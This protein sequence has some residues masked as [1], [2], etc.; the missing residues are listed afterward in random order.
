MAALICILTAFSV[1][2]QI[3]LILRLFILKPFYL[4]AKVQIQIRAPLKLL[5]K[6]FISVISKND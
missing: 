1:V 5:V 3:F 2:P 4:A 6:D